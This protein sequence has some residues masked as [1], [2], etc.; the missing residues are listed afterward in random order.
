[1][2]IGFLFDQYRILYRIFLH[3]YV[4]IYH[5]FRSENAIGFI[6]EFIS[7]FYCV[8]MYVPFQIDIAFISE[9]SESS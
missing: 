7:D 1:M 9:I 3:M 8:S 6:S 2:A 5:H 4:C